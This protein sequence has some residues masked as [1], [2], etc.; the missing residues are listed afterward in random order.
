MNLAQLIDPAWV[1]DRF[2]ERRAPVARPP[3]AKALSE[4]DHG[5][6]PGIQAAI[7]AVLYFNGR[8]GKALS[9][10]EIHEAL[11]EF[12]AFQVTSNVAGPFHSRDVAREGKPRAYRYWLTQRGRAR[13]EG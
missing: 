1:C 3:E 10:A 6:R 4:V 8:G 12:S 5:E 13:L 2:P 7:R 11:P 9:V